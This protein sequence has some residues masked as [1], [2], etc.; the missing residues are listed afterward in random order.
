MELTSGAVTGTLSGW[1]SAILSVQ[2][3]LMNTGFQDVVTSVSEGQVV[4]LDDPDIMM[5]MI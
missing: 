4:C 3:M 1:D 5:Q 2:A